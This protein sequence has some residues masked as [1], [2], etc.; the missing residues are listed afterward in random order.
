MNN[1]NS[2]INAIVLV[3]D[4]SP[5]SLGMLNMALDSAKFTT[6]VALSGTQALSI[7]EKVQPYIILLDA[8]MP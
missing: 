3:V 1:N 7:M 2:P 8:V 5:E 4:D 6:L